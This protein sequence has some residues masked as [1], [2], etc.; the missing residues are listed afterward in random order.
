MALPLSLSFIHIHP[1]VDL[2]AVNLSL[3]IDSCATLDLEIDSL[4]RA[5]DDADYPDPS[6]AWHAVLDWRLFIARECRK[7]L[8]SH[9]SRDE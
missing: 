1:S 8:L 6:V 2:S 4:H 3:S 5:I 7:R 9:R